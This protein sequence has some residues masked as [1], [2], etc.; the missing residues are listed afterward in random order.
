MM[1]KRLFNLVLCVALLL[2]SISSTAF[3]EPA[4]PDQPSITLE[5]GTNHIVDLINQESQDNKLMIFTRSYGT[6]TKP[7]LV[8]TTE[9]IITNEIVT[10]IYTNSTNG[11]YIPANGYVITGTG[12]KASLISGFKIGD[13]ITTSFPISVYPAQYFTVNE[14]I[15][16][17]TQVNAGRGAADIVL[18]LPEYGPATKTNPWGMEITV[19]G[20]SVTRIAT[21][22]QDTS[23]N[24]LDNNSS[25]PAS[26]YVLSIQAESPFFAKLNGTVR[27]GDAVELNMNNEVLVEASKI[28]YDALNPRTREDNPGGWDDGSNEPY[29]GHRGTDQLIIYDNSYGAATGT[30]PWGYEV[31][32]NSEGKVTQVSGNNSTIPAGGYVI[33]GHGVKASW[34]SEHVSIGS[35]FKLLTDEKQA[36]FLFTPESYLDKAQI[37]IDAAKQK[38]I[39]SKQQFLDINYNGM[40]QQITSAQAALVDL[41]SQIAQGDFA[42]FTVQ[43]AELN[44]R[45]EKASFM[46]YES[47]AVDHRSIWI[48]PKETN[49]EQVQQHIAKLHALNINSIYL[50]TWWNGFTI[51]PTSHPLAAQNPIYGGFDVLNAYITEA[52]KAGIEVHAW[53]ENFLVG[54]GSMAG[55]VRSLKPEWSMISRQGHDYQDVPLYNTQYYFLN[56]IRPEVRDFVSEIYKELLQKYKVDGLHLDYIRYPDAGDYTNDFGYDSYTRNLFKQKHGADPIDLRPGDNL[57][58]AWVDFRKNTINEF[59]YRISSEAKKLKPDIRVSAAVWPN[60]VNGP[61]FMHQEPKDWIAKNYID[62]LF[63]MSY[64]PDASSV[65]TDSLNSVALANNKALIVIGVGTNLGLTKEMLLKQINDSVAVGVSGS[66]LFEFESLFGNEYD[67]ALLAGLYSKPAIVPDK[68]VLTSF[69]TI[70]SEMQRK[71]KQIYVPFNGMDNDKKYVKELEQLEKSWKDKKSVGKDAKEALKKIEKLLER[72]E[73]DRALNVEVKKRMAADLNYLETIIL[74]YVS[75]AAH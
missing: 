74:V 71:I 25:I 10:A 45:V 60:Y 48:R 18:Y 37:G 51:Y 42:S 31:V 29:P 14:E 32:V 5:D 58:Q 36:L 52:K 35:S 20:G 3:S 6:T 55:P 4:S 26:G 13:S 41:K 17:I 1:T 50:E 68:D 66:A 23:G 30:N 2:I 33:S 64:H 53:V 28:G 40:E 34:L 15:V 72:I 8:P 22:T 44:A 12:N 57:W 38:L 73:S 70:I 16:P 21:M 61:E 39:L 67:K 7:P 62:Q 46:G 56:P 69:K 27:I 24:W 43:F 47:R 75:K 63:P 49:L 65:A 9:A 59:V 11:T 54:V 19:D